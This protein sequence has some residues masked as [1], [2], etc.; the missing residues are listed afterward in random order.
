MYMPDC[1]KCLMDLAEA[2]PSRLKHHCDY[3]V[4][5]MSF[6]AGE[7]AEAIKEIIP[8]FTCEFEPDQ[9]QEIADSWPNSIDDSAA[10][11]DWGWQ[12]EY[13]LHAMSEDMIEKL[14]KKLS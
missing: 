13:D 10:R 11:K 1:I 5:G 7:L 2:D 9:R 12:P 6:S 4:S 3:N 14:E 8:E